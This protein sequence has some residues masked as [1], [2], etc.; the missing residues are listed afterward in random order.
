LAKATVGLSHSGQQREIASP[1]SLPLGLVV[2][3]RQ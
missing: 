1:Q 2:T 3:A